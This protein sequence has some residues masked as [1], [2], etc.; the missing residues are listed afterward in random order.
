M[1]EEPFEMSWAVQ[2]THTGL[3]YMTQDS[4]KISDILEE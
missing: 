2:H 4:L 3:A 1:H